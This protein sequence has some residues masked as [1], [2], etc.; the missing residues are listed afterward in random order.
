MNFDKALSILGLSRNYNEEDLK[1]AYRRLMAQYHPDLYENKSEKEKKKA[2]EK[3]KDINAARE[4]LEKCL[5]GKQNSN[6]NNNVNS[7]YKAKT[8]FHTQGN[9]YDLYIKFLNKKNDFLKRMNRFIEEIEEISDDEKILY[10]TQNKLHQICK[11]YLNK[12]IIVKTIFEVSILESKF[13]NDVND[14]LKKY[15]EEYCKKYNIVVDINLLESSSLKILHIHLKK[16]RKEKQSSEDITKVL[17]QLFEKYRLYAGFSVIEKLIIGIRNKI[18]KEY[19]SGKLNIEDVVL[20]FDKEVTLEFEDYYKRIEFLDKIKKLSNY[21]EFNQ[22]NVLIE[23]LEENICN[24]SC[25]WSKAYNYL[26]IIETSKKSNS[27]CHF[28]IIKRNIFNN[29]NNY[30][31]S[32]KKIIK[33]RK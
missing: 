33:L 14:I 7:S 24:P 28:Q 20:K 11:I 30:S 12:L 23:N 25:F 27:N 19:R 6:F 10:I 2:E 13:T 26:E 15:A 29:K 21:P 1:K 32:K 18:E 3:T 8:D 16:L 5:K 9:S 17:E 4:Y 22:Y 31:T